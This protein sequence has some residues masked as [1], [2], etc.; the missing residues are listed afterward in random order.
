M[1]IMIS[2]IRDILKD[3]VTPS[4]LSVNCPSNIWLKW[5]WI[6]FVNTYAFFVYLSQIIFPF[7]I[8]CT[9]I[10]I[11]ILH[12]FMI[13]YFPI[14]QRSMSLLLVF[15]RQLCCTKILRDLDRCSRASPHLSLTTPSPDPS[16]PNL[17]NICTYLEQFNQ[18]QER[19]RR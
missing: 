7:K 18:T 13:Y 19:K 14:R 17:F 9:S 10:S 4:T 3:G 8:L 12:L 15:W 5:L 2:F 16:S 6:N 11:F 1:R